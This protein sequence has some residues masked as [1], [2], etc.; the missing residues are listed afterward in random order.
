[1]GYSGLLNSV[2][3]NAIHCL[4]LQFVTRMLFSLLIPSTYS[5]LE[6]T[7]FQPVMIA[8]MMEYSNR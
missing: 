3:V 7:T 4:F 1:M 2:H 5:N 8:H 6:R